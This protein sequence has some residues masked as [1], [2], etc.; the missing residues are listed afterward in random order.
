MKFVS[1]LHEIIHF[2]TST[3]LLFHFRRL[4][5]MR[6][7]LVE[8]SRP[9]NFGRGTKNTQRQNIKCKI[10]KTRT[11]TSKSSHKIWILVEIPST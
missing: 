10:M 2:D 4:Q 11:W 9:K 5:V 3:A 6:K 1:K 7:H 8:G